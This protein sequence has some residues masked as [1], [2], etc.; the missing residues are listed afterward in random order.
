MSPARNTARGHSDW[1][2][3]SQEVERLERELA[4]SRKREHRARRE[5][6]ES[7]ERFER[8]LAATRIFTQTLSGG[9][10]RRKNIGRYLRAEHAVDRALS[11]ASSLEAVAANVLRNLAEHLGW[12]VA[13][14]WVAGE[15]TLRCV[16]DWHRPNAV[17]EG[18]CAGP[19][20]DA[21]LARRA[22]AREA[23]AINGPVWEASRE[24]SDPA[25][26]P[27]GALAFPIN[28]GR[29]VFGAVEL[30]GGQIGDHSEE[31]LYTVRLIGGR[32]GQ[33]VERH[34]VQEEIRGAEAR[35]RFATEAGRLGLLD[36]NVATGES[37]CSGALASIFGLPLEGATLTYEDL[38]ARVYCDDRERVKG[39]FDTSIF[40][41]APYD[42][43]FRITAPDGVRWIHLKGRVHTGEAGK[44]TRV[45]GIML[46]ITEK[47]RTERESERLRSLEAS[48][49]AEAAER[50]R[51]SRELHDRVAHSMG[52]AHQSLQLY[53]ALVERDP[54]RAH[55]K[56]RTAQEMTKLAL[57][58]TRN[59]SMELR[60]SETEDG[61]VPALRGLLEVA[62]PPR[63]RSRCS[64][65]TS[66]GNST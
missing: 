5:I 66:A 53:E 9:R 3:L 27:N 60:R 14:L 54:E 48:I 58:Q 42:L 1:S 46:D 41:G 63:E 51:V 26:G 36:W 28:Q 10:Q 34:Q 64:R 47:K 21:P 30:L 16:A 49:H 45:L 62:S 18:F 8:L 43:E 22:F 17:P 50:D 15:E 12:Q 23:V 59:L 4:A 44:P 65:I 33:F 38:L 24:P 52:V 13:L 32:L 35:L 11:E 6:E 56:L 29:Q 61:L 55:D 31:L 20:A 37:R 19:L 7:R 39:T 40:D 57:E 25:N 2:V